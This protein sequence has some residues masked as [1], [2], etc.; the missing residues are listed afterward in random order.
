MPENPPQLTKKTSSCIQYIFQ[1]SPACHVSP[2]KLEPELWVEPLAWKS[3]LGCQARKEPSSHFQS[4]LFGGYL[5]STPNWQRFGR[6]PQKNRDAATHKGRFY[7]Q[8][9]HKTST[10][11]LHWVAANSGSVS[12]GAFTGSACSETLK[13]TCSAA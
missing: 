7:P 11:V 8:T 6:G 3:K 12:G 2:A 10:E 1:K 9:I 4:S 5:S 13:A